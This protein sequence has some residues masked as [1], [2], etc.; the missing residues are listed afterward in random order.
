RPGL[1]V[2][3]AGGRHR[4]AGNPRLDDADDLGVGGAAAE[5]AALQFD[6]GD[7]VAVRAVAA[8]AARLVEPRAVVDVGLGV[9]VLLRGGGPRR[10][11]AGVG[12]LCSWE[13]SREL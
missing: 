3:E 7:H 13:V 1:R 5:L 10:R 4:R 8:G 9:T 12:S 11:A 6:A 2:G